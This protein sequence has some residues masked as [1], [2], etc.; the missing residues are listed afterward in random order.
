MKVAPKLIA[1]ALIAL[2]LMPVA[3]TGAYAGD[4]DRCGVSDED[5][6]NCK[7]KP[8]FQTKFFSE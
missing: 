6:D 8:K 2:L 3:T 7:K 4:N 5:D 1:A